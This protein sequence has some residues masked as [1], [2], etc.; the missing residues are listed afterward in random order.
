MGIFWWQ[1]NL[2]KFNEAPLYSIAASPDISPKKARHH[3]TARINSTDELN[4]VGDCAD[5]KLYRRFNE[6]WT[7]GTAGDR[8]EL[9]GWRHQF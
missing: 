5:A 6:F 2:N 3:L 9:S 7:P 4:F 8:G 1:K